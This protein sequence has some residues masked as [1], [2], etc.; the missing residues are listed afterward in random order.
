MCLHK[1]YVINILYYTSVVVVV[2]VRIVVVSIAWV[3]INTELNHPYMPHASST[4]KQT[5]NQ[6]KYL[7]THC[8]RENNFSII[9]HSGG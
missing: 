5:N 2:V 8:S 6:H 3:T 7:T 1:Y 9:N 4:R